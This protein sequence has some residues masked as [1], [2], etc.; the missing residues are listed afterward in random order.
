MRCK[1]PRDAVVIATG[2]PAD[3][4]ELRLL[5]AAE[6]IDYSTDVA[7]SIRQLCP[8]GISGLIYLLHPPTNFSSLAS[9][10]QP[11]GRIA[12]TVHAADVDALGALGVT[13]TNVVA[14][15]DPLI[16][17][18][19]GELSRT[20]SLDPRLERVYALARVT[21]GFGHITSATARG[22]LGVSVEP[23]VAMPPTFDPARNVRAS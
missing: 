10:V 12:T 23:T 15:S 18:R 1:S 21:E 6:V 2:L 7:A 19:L 8:A 11:G 17:Q 4:G 20:G 3:E 13:A 5:G 14:S 9:L 16:V 22:K